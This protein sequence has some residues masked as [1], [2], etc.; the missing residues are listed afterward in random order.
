MQPASTGAADPGDLY[1][2]PH[3]AL[4]CCL[5]QALQACG[6]ADAQDAPAMA[7]LHAQVQELL[8]L[9]RAHLRHE[10]DVLHTALEARWPGA[11]CD[12]GGAHARQQLALGELAQEFAAPLADAAALARAYRHLT[13]LVAEQLQH[14]ADEEAHD[15]PALAR[16]YP[17]EAGE[18]LL[19]RLI[20]RMRR[21]DMAIQL[22]W[23]VRGLPP[24]GLQRTLR[25]LR[26]VLG[27]ADLDG[28]LD[29]CGRGLGRAPLSRLRAARRA[30]SLPSA[31][32]PHAPRAADTGSPRPGGSACAAPPG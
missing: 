10:N 18:Q 21:D 26:R 6:R 3:P 13:A 29:A 4:R 31:P 23:M 15:A 9:L 14:M 2:L 24:D 28:L 32:A 7:A 20:E 5:A 17:S 8:A 19:H 1:I 30:L 12:S 25:A 27:P 22:A 16:G 11:A